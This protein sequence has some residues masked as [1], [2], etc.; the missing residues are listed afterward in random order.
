M[1]MKLGSSNHRNFF[2]N[3]SLAKCFLSPSS[4]IWLS[5]L[6]IRSTLSTWERVGWVGCCSIRSAYTIVRFHAGLNLYKNPAGAG[7][8][9]LFLSRQ[10]SPWYICPMR[11]VGRAN[12]TS[13]G[14][15]SEKKKNEFSPLIKMPISICFSVEVIRKKKLPNLAF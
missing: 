10:E 8:S 12:W 1:E 9:P 6:I 7:D 3:E 15:D 11:Q 14:E 4:I 5:E 13:N 2:S